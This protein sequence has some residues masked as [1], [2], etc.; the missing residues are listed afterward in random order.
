MPQN[1]ISRGSPL[2]ASRSEQEAL[3]AAVGRNPQLR[4]DIEAVLGLS[5]AD[6]SVG[7]TLGALEDYFAAGKAL[8]AVNASTRAHLE[9]HQLADQTR[10]GDGEAIPPPRSSEGDPA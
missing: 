8:A 4:A 7:Q 6:G 1:R 9:A 2:R 5:L 10:S 3:L